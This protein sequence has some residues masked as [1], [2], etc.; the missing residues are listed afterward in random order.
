MA[1][2]RSNLTCPI[3]PGE[4]TGLTTLR[5]SEYR[6]R[7][8]Q[9]GSVLLISCSLPCQIHAN[10]RIRRVY[11]SDRLYSEDELPAEFKLYLPVQNKTGSKVWYL[12]FFRLYTLQ[13]M[14]FFP[15]LAHSQN[16]NHQHSLLPRHEPLVADLLK[17]CA[18]NVICIPFL[19]CVYIQQ[20]KK[21]NFPVTNLY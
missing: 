19:S 1:G 2:T 13:G 17:V 14:F 18:D 4:R 11:F 5:P 20:T 9:E 16:S 7:Y 12:F 21:K 10:C 6:Y 15:F 8:L 3:S